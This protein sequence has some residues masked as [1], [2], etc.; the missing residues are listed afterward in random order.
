MKLSAII[1]LLKRCD[2]VHIT[3]QVEHVIHQCVALTL[4]VF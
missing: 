4:S 1:I 3:L 2:C